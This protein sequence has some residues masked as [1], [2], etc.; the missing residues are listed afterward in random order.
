MLAGIVQAPGAQSLLFFKS[1][2]T[3]ED[4]GTTQTRVRGV[5]DLA[6][7]GEGSISANGGFI[8][9]QASRLHSSVAK[10]SA[11]RRDACTTMLPRFRNRFSVRT[12]C[13][14]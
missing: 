3:E 14:R 10:L 9:V 5:R 13:S 1:L 6:S 12:S 4:Y 11:G 2:G 7:G 8:V